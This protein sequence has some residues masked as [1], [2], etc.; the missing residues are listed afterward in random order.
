MIYDIWKY[1]LKK[2]YDSVNTFTKGRMSTNWPSDLDSVCIPRD[3]VLVY[4]K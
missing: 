2:D 1:K 3:Q 4:G